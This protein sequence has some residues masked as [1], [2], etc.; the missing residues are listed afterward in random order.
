MVFLSYQ[1]GKQPQVKALYQ[2]LT[3]LGYSVWM[4]IYQMGGG[5]SLYDKID[6][7]MRGCKAVVSCVTQKYSLSANCRREVSLADALKKPIVPLL[8]EEMKW[9]PD[10]PMSMVFTELLYINFHRD[11]AVQLIWTGQQFEE[12]KD[13][14]SQFVPDVAV[15]TERKD[16]YQRPPEARNKTMKVESE[17]AISEEREDKNQRPRESQDKKIKPVS[18]A[19][20]NVAR[21]ASPNKKAIVVRKTDERESGTHTTKG[22]AQAGNKT[23]DNKQAPVKKPIPVSKGVLAKTASMNAFSRENDINQHKDSSSTNVTDSR[24][25]PYNSAV[26]VKKSASGAAAVNSE[27]LKKGQKKE[28]VGALQSDATPKSPKSGQLYSASVGDEYVNGNINEGKKQAEVVYPNQIKSGGDQKK[29]SS[30]II[31]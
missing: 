29:S 24:E 14:L 4:D 21:S 15:N 23:T 16:R 30:C 9:P 31:L 18:T 2:R 25:P 8:L 27:K 13:K 19:K 22:M 6:R 1:W 3:S 28:S 11:E 17:V 10:G 20:E 7:G 26:T 5:D 12:L